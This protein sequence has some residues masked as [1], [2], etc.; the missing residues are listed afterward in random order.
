MLGNR[1]IPIIAL[2]SSIA[3]AAPTLT[4]AAGTITA[5]SQ[6]PAWNSSP[7]IDLGN[8]LLL[9]SVCHDGGQPNSRTSIIFMNLGP[10][11]AT[12]N[13]LFSDGHTVDAT[14]IFQSGTSPFGEEKE[15]PFLHGRIEGQFIWAKAAVTNTIHLHAFDGNGFCEIR[16]TIENAPN[17]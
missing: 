17:Q 4:Q 13:W 8:G 10:D 3:P 2:A 5:I 15:I 16:G 7:T 14:G 6:L 12:L 9:F 11:W 1:V